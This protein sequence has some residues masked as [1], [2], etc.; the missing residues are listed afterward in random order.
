MI[1]LE[2]HR[3]GGSLRRILLTAWSLAL[4]A[5]CGPP[6]PALSENEPIAIAE[7]EPQQTLAGETF[8]EVPGGLSTVTIRAQGAT[9]DTIV[10]LNGTALAS[11]VDAYGIIKAFIPAEH[12]QQPGRL[13]L[14]LY[15]EPTSRVSE[16]V[17]LEVEGIVVERYGPTEITAGVDFNPQPSGNSGIWLQARNAARGTVLLA[18][19]EPLKTAVTDSGLVT[20]ELPPRYYDAPGTLTLTLVDR[21]ADLRSADLHIPILGVRVVDYGPRRTDPGVAFNPQPDGASALWFNLAAPLWTAIVTWDGRELQTSVGADGV[22]SAL[23][24]AELIARPG[25]HRLQIV[26]SA[27]GMKSEPMVFQVGD[28]APA[29]ATPV[30]LAPALDSIQIYVKRDGMV[31][32]AGFDLAS[33]GLDLQ[34]T[35]GDQLNLHLRGEPVPIV[36]EGLSP[37]GTLAPDSTILFWGEF[38]RGEQTLH[39]LHAAENVYLLRWDGGRPPVRYTMSDPLSLPA[40]DEPILTSCPR[41]AHL[42]EDREANFLQHYKGFPTDRVMWATFMAPPREGHRLTLGTLPDLAEGAAPSAIRIMLWGNSRLGIHPDHRWRLALNGHDLGEAVWDDRTHVVHGA[43]IPERAFSRHEPMMAA[44]SEVELTRDNNLELR[45]MQAGETIDSISID[46]VEIDYEAVL[47]PID[48]RLTYQFTTGTLA[49]A[50]SIENAFSGAPRIFSIDEGIELALPAGSPPDAIRY[51]YEVKPDSAVTR[52]RFVAV[53]P[54]GYLAPERIESGFASDLKSAQPPEYLVITHARFVEALQPLIEH[55]RRQ[56]LSTLLVDVQDI[57][58]EYSDSLFSPEA[59]RRFLDDLFVKE[60]QGAGDLQYV[61]LVGDA[62]YDYHNVQKT[63]PNLVPTYHIESERSVGVPI[64]ALDE[65]YVYGPEGTTPR[66]AIGRLPASRPAQVTDYVEKLVAFEDANREEAV[67]AMEG[68]RRAL[69]I[70]GTGFANY[71]DQ[72]AEKLGEPW[73]ITRVYAER[74]VARNEA[75]RGQIVAALNGGCDLVYFAGHGSY[76][77]WRTGAEDMASQT[78]MLTNAHVR[79]LTNAGRYPLIF[80]ATC[81]SSLFDSPGYAH[82]TNNEWVDS[83]IGTYLVEAP[84]RGGIACIGHVGE[85]L[86]LASHKFILRMIESMR[87]QNVVRLG[88]AF[89]AAK[90]ESVGVP[91]L[92]ITLIGDPAT[93]LGVRFSQGV[94]PAEPAPAEPAGA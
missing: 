29:A 30:P 18:N 61:F 3:W 67:A 22:V 10:R 84:G 25:F 52:P 13:A 14:S 92:G 54:R 21:D 68:P 65:Y 78:D 8:A 35:R 19:G 46:W 90:R 85:S 55:R 86:V 37:S 33:R 26:D 89:L 73:E 28:V 39:D 63:V 70:A 94:G 56:G 16:P 9:S 66:V 60:G 87:E 44:G 12:L 76:W 91:Y 72:V 79:E 62:N 40:P 80:S 69:L 27:G 6:P 71:C 48:D 1:L 83:G 42:E 11:R 23:V 17:Y 15:D 31:R 51:R 64:F 93:W 38:P 45:N 5:A 32:L 50:V 4:L 41:T 53:G 34:A 57:Y 75:L 20:A 74:D 58:D 43:P 59:I 77:E 88:D 82:P 36:V 47:R 49:Q 2:L 7:Y 24:P 81:Y